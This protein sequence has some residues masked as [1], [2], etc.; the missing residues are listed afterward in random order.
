MQRSGFSLIE[1]LVVVA[2]IG[3]LAGVGTIGYLTYI[4]Q[5]QDGT[6]KDNF[7][8]LKRTLNQDIL[9]VSND[10]NSR[11]KFAEGIS[12]S[13]E[14]YKLRDKYIF[15]MNLERSNP[16]NK[17]KGQVCDGNHFMT[18]LLQSDS[19]ATTLD[20]PRGQTMV[21]CTGKTFQTAVQKTISSKIGLQ[22]CTCTGR[23]FCTTTERYTAKLQDNATA[24]DF[25][26]LKLKDYNLP[27]VGNRLK[28]LLI[29][30]ETV[31]V[32]LGTYND[33]ATPH[34][35]DVR[36]LR[37]DYPIDTNIYEINSD[38]CFTPLGDNS[39]LADYRADF[40]DLGDNATPINPR[41]RCY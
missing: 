29:G 10:L 4:S 17:E 26:T 23:D 25:A 31:D 34:T 18:Y 21:Y 24:G 36:G 41:H 32:D 8:F 20:L 19:T 16:F 39:D 33:N 14:C 15:D 40:S 38:Y 35:V 27:T 9:S 28:R 37:S 13:S 3:I 22:F 2:I 11:S 12:K 7:E 5:A 30:N 1:L 6:T